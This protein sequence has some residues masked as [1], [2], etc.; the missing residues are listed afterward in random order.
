MGCCLVLHLLYKFCVF[1][2][3]VSVQRGKSDEDHKSEQFLRNQYVHV[4]KCRGFGISDETGD[5]LNCLVVIIIRIQRINLHD[6]YEHNKTNKNLP[7]NQLPQLLDQ[8]ASQSSR[9]SNDSSDGF[10][11]SC[12]PLCPMCLHH[13]IDTTVYSRDAL[14]T[15]TDYPWSDCGGTAAKKSATPLL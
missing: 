14:A 7:P 9:S 13:C 3:C 10:S 12:S 1:Q 8:Q 4:S 11:C 2:H 15:S 5:R 6:L